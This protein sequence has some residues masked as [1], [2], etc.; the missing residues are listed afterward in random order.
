MRW[1]LPSSPTRPS[2]PSAEDF[3]SSVVTK[4]SGV[5]AGAPFHHDGS[6]VLATRSTPPSSDSANWLSRKPST[7][8]E[9]TYVVLSGS[10]T[11]NAWILV[12]V[13]GGATSSSTCGASQRR[14][15]TYRR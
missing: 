9:P 11:S 14:V 6:L 5:F 7:S 15:E 8:P 2:W 10:V 1:P 3:A 4:L 12:V 13:G